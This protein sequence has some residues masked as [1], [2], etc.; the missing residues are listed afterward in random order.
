MA[1]LASLLTLV[2]VLALVGFILYLIFKYIPM[3]EPYKQSLMVIIVVIIVI[4]LI[5]MLANGSLVHF[6]RI[7]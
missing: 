2:L 3:P 6:G 1:Q 7:G 4:Y 5:S